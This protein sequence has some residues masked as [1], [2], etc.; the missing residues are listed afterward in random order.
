MKKKICDY[1]G[2]EIIKKVLMTAI[3]KIKE[4]KIYH[5]QCYLRK[6]KEEVKNEKIRR[7]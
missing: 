7:F 2:K 5:W 1:C 6:I 4:W 3:F